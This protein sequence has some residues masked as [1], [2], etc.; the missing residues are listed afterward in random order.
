M[1]ERIL[2]TQFGQFRPAAWGGANRSGIQPLCDKVLVL[3][4]QPMPTHGSI[5]IPESIQE[6]QGYAATTG[7]LVATGSQAFAYDSDRL[8]RWDGARPVPGVRIF[9]QKYAGQDYMGKDGLMYRL[10]QDRSIAGVEIEDQPEPLPA[11]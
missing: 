5:I 1:E 2:D 11:A 9:F 6:T 3:P 10:M 7:L 8:T 4:D